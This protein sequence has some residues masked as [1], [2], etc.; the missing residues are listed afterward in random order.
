MQLGSKVHTSW[1]PEVEFRVLMPNPS[2]LRMINITMSMSGASWG[3]KISFNETQNIAFVYN[4]M[5]IMEMK[6]EERQSEGEQ[7]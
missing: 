1:L 7:V 4:I 6:N 3:S 5:K 2:I